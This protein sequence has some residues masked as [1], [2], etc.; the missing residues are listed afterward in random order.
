MATEEI[1]FELVNHYKYNR[2]GANGEW[3]ASLSA[4]L[5]TYY[6]GQSYGHSE[7]SVV[8]QGYSESAALADVQ[9]KFQQKL[10]DLKQKKRAYFSSQSSSYSSYSPSSSSYSSS[11][12]RR[13]SNAEEFVSLLGILLSCAIAIVVDRQ[14]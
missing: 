9:F 10:E 1:S 14:G 3:Y 4:D 6:R 2:R 8:G 11:G 5:V 7:V 13:I 12:S